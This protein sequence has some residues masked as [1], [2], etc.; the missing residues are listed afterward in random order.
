MAETST[1][2][3]TRGDSYDAVYGAFRWHIPRRYN[4]AADVC[5]RHAAVPG[6]TALI[7]FDDRGRERHLSFADVRDAANG[8]ANALAAHGVALGLLL[9]IALRPGYEMTNEPFAVS[10]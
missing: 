7:W 5:D 3:L 8:F 2:L 10:R 9:N 1:P 4:M 6:K